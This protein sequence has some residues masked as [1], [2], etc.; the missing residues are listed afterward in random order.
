MLFGGWGGG[1]GGGDVENGATY[2][3]SIKLIRKL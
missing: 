3:E 1:V 2:N